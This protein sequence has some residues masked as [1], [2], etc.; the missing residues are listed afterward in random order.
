MRWAE[1]AQL[2]QGEYIGIYLQQAAVRDRAVIKHLQ[3]SR[4]MDRN[5]WQAAWGRA[6]Q[7]TSKQCIWQMLGCTWF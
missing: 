5:E 3:T 7:Q 4:M 6:R 2:P 1:C